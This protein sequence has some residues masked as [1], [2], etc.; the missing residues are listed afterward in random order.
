MKVRLRQ[1]LGSLALLGPAIVAGVAYLDPGNVATNLSAGAGFGYTLTWVI[2]MANLVAWLVQYLSAKLGLVTGMSLPE[3]LGQRFRSRWARWGFWLQAEAV[4]IATDVAEV[5]GGAIA[6]NLL[7]NLPLLAGGII[8][9]AISLALLSLHSRGLIRGFEFVIFGLVMVTGVGFVA[10]LFLAPPNPSGILSGVLPSFAGEE[11]VLLAAGIVGA[12]IM[13]HAI[14]AHSALSRDRFAA[15]LHIDN[16][17]VLLRATK[18][19]VSIAMFFAGAINLAILFVGATSLFGTA[20]EQT[21]SGAYDALNQ[22]LGTGVAAFF[23]IGLLASG[24]ASSSV[25]TYAGG[26][27]MQGL[28]RRKM[29]PMLLRALTL[30]PALAVIALVENPTLA[31]VYSQVLLSFGLPF[32]LF[33]LVRLTS[34]KS[35]MGIHANRRGTAILGFTLAAAISALNLYL[36]W[37]TGQSLLTG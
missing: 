15:F 10:A 32:A 11:S 5:V 24:L 29:S 26:I 20:I 33:P 8:T 7:F 19:D 13:P 35:V 25:G 3:L 17:K 36:L 14:Y 9:G 18:W 2:V 12:T 37:L 21:I 22:A 28:L 4:A 34:S 23:A 16:L 31:L 6:L 27:I 30:L 1:R